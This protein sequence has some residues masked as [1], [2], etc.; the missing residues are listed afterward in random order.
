MSTGQ[1]PVWRSLNCESPLD[2]RFQL[3]QLSYTHH[4]SDILLHGVKTS[5]PALHQELKVGYSHPA[6]NTSYCSIYP[7]IM[8]RPAGFE[9]ATLGLAYQLR[10]STPQYINWVCG[11]DYLFTITGVARIVSTDPLMRP[12]AQVSSGLPSA[13]ITLAAKVSPIQCDPLYRFPE[14]GQFPVKAPEC[15]RWCMLKGRC[16]IQLSYGRKSYREQ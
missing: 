2:F 4:C 6:I 3:T 10:L 14:I 1:T 16:S 13:Q 11:L 7:N 8:A 5:S 15:T 9:P 12:V